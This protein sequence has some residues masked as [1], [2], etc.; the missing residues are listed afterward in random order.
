MPTLIDVAEAAGVSRSTVSNVFAHPELVRVE[1]RQRVEAAARTLGYAGPDPKGKLLREGRFH[2]IG[3]CGVGPG[4]LADR[5][6]GAYGRELIGGIASV[7]DAHDVALTLLPGFGAAV[8]RALVDGLL[9]ERPEDMARARS[10][11]LPCV[12]FDSASGIDGVG[13]VAVDARAGAKLAADHIAALGHRQLVII[14]TARD[15]EPPRFHAPGRNRE[16]GSAL[17]LERDKLRGYSEGLAAAGVMLERIPIIEAQATSA[18]LG[19]VLFERAPE[20]TAV[21]AMTDALGFAVAA[22]AKQRGLSVPRDLSI[23]GFDGV[24]EGAHA[25][26]PLTTIAHAIGEKGR[27]AARMLLGDDP[28]RAVTLPVRLIGRASTAAPR[29]TG[30]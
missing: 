11:N 22:A 20:A 14:A 17:P 24:L 10:R 16:L 1:V 6:S 13:S 12:L 5:G 18:D 26:P 25:E 29:K 9:L 4:S 19:A 27:L 15:G 7:C 3:L 2:A 23:V 28:M 30:R 8:A 21:L